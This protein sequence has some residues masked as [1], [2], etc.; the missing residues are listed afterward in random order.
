MLGSLHNFF[1]VSSDPGGLVSLDKPPLGL[2]LQTVSAAVFGFHPLSLLLP[3]ALCVVAAVGVVY[4][5]VA[6]RFGSWA[7]VGAAATL[8]VF[9]A[10]VASGRDNNLDALLILLMV[11]ACGVGLR[12]VET[13]GWRWLV[14]TAVLVGLAFNTKALAAVL[15]VPGL[16]VG[17][18]VCA[19]GSLRRRVGLLAGAG[20]VLVVV[21]LV[22]LV[23][24]DLT[25]AAQRPYVGASVDNSELSLVFGQNGFGRVL[26]ERGAPGQIVHV[27]RAKLERTTLAAAT[28]ASIPHRVA[29]SISSTG[30]PGLLR[31]FNNADG[32]Q[33]AWMLPFALFGL[34]AIALVVRG[35]GRRDKRLVV[36]VVL[37]GWV[38]VEA[39]VLSVST[40]IVHPYY[41]SALGPG[42]AALVGGG[43]AAFVE[44]GRRSRA[45]LV[46]PAGALAVT[47]A[48]AIMLLHRDYDYLH[49]LWPVLIGVVGA[50][51]ALM[52]WHPR[53]ASAAIA[54]GLAASLVVPAI[55]SAT[56]WQVP[57]NGT[58]PVAGPYIQDNL[59]AYGIPPDDVDS[60]RTLIRYVR[61]REPGSRWDVLT[62]GSNAAAA[63]T[64]VGGR[65]AALGGYGT[66]D[67]VLR[68][69][70]LARLVA[71]GEVRFVALGGGYASR[72]G[73]AASAAVAAVCRRIAPQHWRS[74][75]NFGTAA[76]PRYLYPHGGWNLVLYDCGGR[77]RELATAA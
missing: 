74:P 51:L 14:A 34:V 49:W 12:A 15:V 66:T 20:V 54:A 26:G 43:A 30:S 31:L 48:V 38:V 44:L 53:L 52:P 77:S 37:G 40:G 42:V 65:A 3:G 75:H 39:V 7:G 61:P 22:W 63:L 56:V 17:W 46:L 1:F 59:D 21:S 13:G 55:Y 11:L 28:P 29:G 72:G 62:Q 33:G 24:V 64:L 19:P 6:P 76:H 23:A 58:F 36:L 60:Y 50:A 4:W 45:Y 47:V 9:P 35:G 18:L 41:V 16:A 68:P 5:V 25:P 32:A 71:R 69:A 2:W 57:V 10:L 27:R 67:P 8:A 70:G 73:N